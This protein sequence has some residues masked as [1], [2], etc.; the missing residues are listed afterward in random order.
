MARAA[1]LAHEREGGTSVMSPASAHDDDPDDDFRGTRADI[2]EI[3]RKPLP[4]GSAAKKFP[5]RPTSCEQRSS[6]PPSR[7][8]EAGI[9]DRAEASCKQPSQH[10]RFETWTHKPRLR[11]VPIPRNVHDGVSGGVSER[12]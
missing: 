6:R 10:S 2:S 7:W 4:R 11:L 5:P 3:S 9:W 1:E 8:A 12:W